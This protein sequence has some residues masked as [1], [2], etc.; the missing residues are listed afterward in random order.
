VSVPH[1]HR[2][3]RR[4][5]G[6]LARP[7]CTVRYLERGWAA[8]FVDPVEQLEE[9]ADLWARGVLTT[10]EFEHEKAKIIGT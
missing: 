4:E 5:Q 6:L 8:Q 3:R 1:L 10:E 7:P 9:L 2:S